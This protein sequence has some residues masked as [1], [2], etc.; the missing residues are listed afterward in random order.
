MNNFAVIIPAQEKNR[1]HELGDIAPF[2]DTTLLEWK[3]AQ[4]KEFIR[5]SQIYINSESKNIEE[6]AIRSNVN[7]IE[8]EPRLNYIDMVLDSIFKVK[9]ENIIWTNCTSPFLNSKSYRL[10][11]DTFQGRC[12]E[13]V[14]SVHKQQEYLFFRNRMLNFSTNFIS[15][16]DIEPVYM[17]TNGCYIIKKEIALKNKNLFTKEPFLFE[18]D[19][20]ES[21]EIKD[22]E[23]Y[24]FAKELINVYF[25]KEICG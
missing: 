22:I 11:A 14:I 10:M 2:G 15:R 3:I 1:Y 9:E 24:A 16:R 20:F 18:L 23:D 21:I 13:S 8:R 5:S 7:F 12:L 4:C 6:I 25:R 19:S 17:V